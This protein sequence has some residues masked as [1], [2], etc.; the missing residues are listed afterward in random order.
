MNQF[1]L[2]PGDEKF[3][4]DFIEP[5]YGPE[6]GGILQSSLSFYPVI[7]RQSATLSATITITKMT[8]KNIKDACSNACSYFRNSNYFA[9]E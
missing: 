9:W 4:I 1:F 7:L 8:F 2:I 6:S 3:E 5:T